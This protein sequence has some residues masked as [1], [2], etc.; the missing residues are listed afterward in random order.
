M[1][2]DEAVT[3]QA[4]CSTCVRT[5]AEWTRVAVMLITPLFLDALLA[6]RVYPLEE[7]SALVAICLVVAWLVVIGVQWYYHWWAGCGGNISWKRS[8]HFD[9]C[10]CLLVTS[11]ALRTNWYSRADATAYEMRDAW[12]IAAIIAQGTALRS[13]IASLDHLPWWTAHCSRSAAD[14]VEGKGNTTH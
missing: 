12:W 13:F 8:M 6:W 1:P 11:A 3:S 7:D 14:D 10:I 4:C 2:A 5:L 9:A